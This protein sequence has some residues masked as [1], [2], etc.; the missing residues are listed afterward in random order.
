[1]AVTGAS[2]GLFNIYS[3]GGLVFV[4]SLYTYPYAF[5]FVSNSLELMSSEMEDAAAILGAG[6]WQVMRMVT[7]PL[8][9]P[10]LIA[11]F[12]MAFLEAIADL[13]APLLLAVPARV[14]VITTQLFQFFSFP[15]RSKWRRR[16]RCR[17][18]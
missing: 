14:Q 5:L 2:S 13:G 12:I 8:V 7:I 10:A 16:I 15:R 1:M 17:C 3:L 4:M 6:M 9:L 18:C 11:G